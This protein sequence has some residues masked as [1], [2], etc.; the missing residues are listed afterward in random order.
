ML[1]RLSNE[2]YIEIDLTVDDNS[3]ELIAQS[4][5]LIKVKCYFSEA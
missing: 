3:E 4:W 5:S 2:N 1:I